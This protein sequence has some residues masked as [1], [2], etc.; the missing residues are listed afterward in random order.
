MNINVLW[1]WRE[2]R[3]YEKMLMEFVPFLIWG[4][5]ECTIDM[6]MTYKYILVG[7]LHIWYLRFLMEDFLIRRLLDKWIVN[8]PILPILLIVIQYVIVD[9]VGMHSIDV[10][11]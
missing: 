2:F 3:V 10:P 11:I 5:I 1:V 4:I 6:G 9:I 8:N 7:P